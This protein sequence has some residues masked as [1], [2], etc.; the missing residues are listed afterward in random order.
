[1]NNDIFIKELRKLYTDGHVIPFIGAGLSIPF[2]VP[3]WG[4]LIRNCAIDT[5]IEN[6][7]GRSLLGTLDLN[8]ERYDY[9]E[10]VRIIKKY[11]NRSEED[12]QEY[13]VDKIKT[14]SVKS[15]DGS[16]HNYSDLG[17]MDFDIF[18]TTNYDHLL[19]DYLN[20]NY[21]P[22]KL[23]DIN[24]NMQKLL[25]EKGSKRIFHLHGHISDSS[26]IVISEEKYME[27]YNDNKYKTLF[28]LFAGVKTFLFIG[29]SFKDVFIQNIIKDNKEFFKSKHYIV[30]ESPT[31][32]EVSW[33]KKNYNLETISYDK[34]NSS[35]HE[36]I[37]KILNS[38]CIKSDAENNRDNIV[39]I[40]HNNKKK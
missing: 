27:L 40:F 26:S 32:E 19:S 7:D 16:W 13:I 18:L 2:K 38:I 25:H 33:L 36:E 31:T 30:L 1:M 5:G 35:H 28:S 8:L 21:V 22:V 14:E 3:G 15:I 29:F 6:V 9:W 17:T 12:I 34:N 10:A 39:D 11:L 23:Q 20:S 4:D 24:S 37:R